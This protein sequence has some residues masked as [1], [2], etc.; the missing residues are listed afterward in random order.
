[1][2][3]AIASF[4]AAIC[5]GLVLLFSEVAGQLYFL[6]IPGWSSAHFPLWIRFFRVAELFFP[7]PLMMQFNSGS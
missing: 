3:P 4:V 6:Y 1:M 2:G 5:I 7:P